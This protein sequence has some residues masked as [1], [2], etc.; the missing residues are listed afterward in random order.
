M[1]GI[2]VDNVWLDLPVDLSVRLTRY[3]SLFDFETV[4]GSVVND[5]SVP[6]TPN[7]DKVFGWFR[8]AKMK[9]PD[10]LY[11]CEKIAD[12]Y[13]IERGFIEL[14]DCTETEY[15]L[16]FTQNLSEVFGEYQNVLLT[17]LPLGGESTITPVAAANYL[18]D[19]VCWPTVNNT[20]F[21]GT[22]VQPG[23]NGKMN[24][25]VAGVINTNAR[26]PMLFLRWFF[27]K[28]GELCNFQFKGTFFESD[29]Y[30]RMVV[31]NTRSLDDE[32]VIVYNNHVPEMTLPDL[33]KEIRRLFNLAIYFDVNKRI[34]YGYWGNELLEKE[35][36]LN[37]TKKVIPSM[38]R[39]PERA[40]RLRLDWDLDGND[41]MMKVSPLPDG[42]SAYVT[43]ATQNGSVFEVR[44]KASTFVFTAGAAVI[45]QVG[46]SVRFN[47]AGS[48]FGFRL[49][50][51]SGVV[52]GVPSISNNYG[53]Y[54]LAW[55]GT[56]NL[57][58]KCYSNYERLRLRTSYK[59]LQANL[60][61]LDLHRID[62]H[63]NPDAE[64]AVF[65]DGKEYYVIS[66]EVLLPL[67]G[68]SLLYLVE[69][70]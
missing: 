2:K 62:W 59:T 63:N 49:G 41:N 15:I 21:Y 57:V 3:N 27:E 29:I 67:Q 42:F 56:D 8:E 26:V 7:N 58:D 64:Q 69:K 35:T 45:E 1:F 5:F 39:T 25:W 23:Y 17:Q 46:G 9:L 44:T 28:V 32:S 65:I 13:V 12:G 50:F 38:A 11:Y 19:K 60:N 40:N 16:A 4:R 31:F 37:W 20:A 53:G 70:P 55:S 61:A 68:Q 54:R 30:K 22:N 6:F 47:Q 52:A 24:E 14:V 48:K 10:K 34:M 66:V 33:I 43:P 18:S 51:W 36:K